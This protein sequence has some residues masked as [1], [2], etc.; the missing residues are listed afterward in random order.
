MKEEISSKDSS[1]QFAST[2]LVY[3]RFVKQVVRHSIHYTLH[4]LIMTTGG[5]QHE[6]EAIRRVEAQMENAFL[7]SNV[8]LMDESANHHQFP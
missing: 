6:I 4:T 8:K 5:V 7:V 2:L 1:A 3:G